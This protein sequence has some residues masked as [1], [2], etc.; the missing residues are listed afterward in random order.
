M[1]IE[2]ESDKRLLSIISD[3][4]N[5]DKKLCYDCAT[6]YNSDINCPACQNTNAAKPSI[7]DEIINDEINNANEWQWIVFQCRPST[8]VRGRRG[9][10]R[11]GCLCWRTVRTK[12]TRQS[13]QTGPCTSCGK[14]Q[15]VNPGNYTIFRSRDEAQGFI[16]GLEL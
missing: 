9:D 4:S 14:R 5:G 8:E 7:N 3:I 12:R 6:I 1:T 15:R 13:F 10:T 16:S 2:N 11:L